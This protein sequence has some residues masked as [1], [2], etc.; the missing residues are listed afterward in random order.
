MPTIEQVRKWVADFESVYPEELPD[1][2]RWFVESL[3]VSPKRLLRLMGVP[4]D[5]SERLAER[6]VDW[7]RAVEQFGEEPAWWAESAIRQAIVFYQYD[8]QALKERLARPLDSDYGFEVPEPGGRFTALA[9]LPAGRWED[10]LLDRIAQG[11]LQATMP[12]VAY[13]S[14]PESR[15]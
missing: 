13:L 5:Q 3:G 1:R 9:D 15:P 8:W 14:Q 7:A 10:V 2:L 11:G 12:L 4:R 6:G